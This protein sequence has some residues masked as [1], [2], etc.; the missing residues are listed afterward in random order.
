MIVLDVFHIFWYF[1]S[2]HF[3]QKL[4]IYLNSQLSQVLNIVIFRKGMSFLN[5]LSGVR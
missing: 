5:D 1:I 4:V 3:C 2:N